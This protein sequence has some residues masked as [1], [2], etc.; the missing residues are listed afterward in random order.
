MATWFDEAYYLKAK[1]AQLK[2]V[3]EKDGNGNDYTLTT[4]KKAIADN[5]MTPEEH[6][7]AYGRSEGVNPNAYF[8]EAEYLQAKLEQLH[9]VNETDA[10]GNPYTLTTLKE[11]I[12]NIGLTPAEHYELYG[13]HETNKDGTLINPSNAFD[14]NAYAAAKLHQLQHGTAEERAAW[15]D[16]TPA[17]VMDAIRDA[18][19]SPVTHYMT[20]GAA[21]AN[22]GKVPMVQTVPSEQRVANDPHRDDFGQNVPSNYNAPTPAPSEADA[23][24]VTKPADMGGMASTD[25]SPQVV[26]PDKP[27]AVPGDKGYVTPPAG[28]VDTND[29]PVV[30]VVDPGSG[31]LVVP[32]TPDPTPTPDP[33]PTP[34]TPVAPVKPVFSDDKIAGDDTIDRHELL[35]GVAISGAA[36]AGSTVKILV[37]DNNAS[38]SDVTLT[39]TAAA[40]G[41]FTATLTADMAEGLKDG[42]LTLTAT[43]SNSGGTSGTTT[44]DG[45]TLDAKLN[46]TFSASGEKPAVK[47]GLT[48][49]EGFD[50]TTPG[51]GTL[52]NE[53]QTV[54]DNVTA[55]NNNQDYANVSALEKAAPN[56]AK[57]VHFYED[58]YTVNE[59]ATSSDTDGVLNLSAHDIYGGG[60]S[61][62]LA[63]LNAATGSGGRV[64]ALKYILGEAKFDLPVIK[65]S[66][67]NVVNLEVNKV[68]STITEK[69]DSSLWHNDITF[70]ELV[71]LVPGVKPIAVEANANT[72]DLRLAANATDKD[73]KVINLMEVR[74]TV[75][76]ITFSGT[77]GRFGI[78]VDAGNVSTIDASSL[79]D[80]NSGVY[81]NTAP[82]EV[83]VP[84][85]M[86]N[87]AK[88]GFHADSA[89]A[90]TFKGSAGNDILGVTQEV[91]GNTSSS[92]N[93][94][95]GD[96]TLALILPLEDK[97]ENAFV[98]KISANKHLSSFEHMAFVRLGNGVSVEDA[99]A[100]GDVKEFITT[101]DLHIE[102][103]TADQSVSTVGLLTSL[104]L[105]LS[106]K[107]KDTATT[108]NLAMTDNFLMHI[109]QLVGD[110][111]SS[112]MPHG[113]AV[114][115]QAENIGTLNL[116]SKDANALLILTEDALED[117]HNA[118]ASAKIE[119]TGYAGSIKIDDLRTSEAAT[120]VDAVKGFTENGL[121]VVND[122]NSVTIVYSDGKSS[123]EGDWT[124]QLVGFKG[125]VANVNLSR[126]YAGNYDNPF[127]DDPA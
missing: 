126:D 117:I 26:S 55:Q 119:A 106:A 67:T 27:V 23:A 5:G 45:I 31:Q 61:L 99:S 84:L 115:E 37:S 51:L 63:A 64:A 77:E 58:N 11:A 21:E 44:K 3:G 34:P 121:Y 9:S 39:T 41:T 85:N 50:N 19:M 100:F 101:T 42:K 47:L 95:G 22:A 13:S 65:A 36:K 59:K 116:T 24:P 123:T 104:A 57:L 105:E 79:T 97:G 92:F 2:A 49:P 48:A 113:A 86:G 80:K 71:G 107:E 72:L 69:I 89:E 10:H 62:S 125:A 91:Y 46:A 33:D 6:Y 78:N 40:N 52:M 7:N 17:D 73:A 60:L 81:V 56:F 54:Y 8:N 124:V 53:L 93:G 18:G 118:S 102:N 43:A 88:L 74:G 68:G 108:L 20:Y 76:N 75:E 109:D 103:L 70:S 32:T 96:D 38:T 122:D 83:S 25:V 98:A 15:A 110:T 90:L 4:L 127:A 30:P 14:A 94:E 87:E 29:H 66:A 120:T 16:K 111:Q 35:S 28:T 114:L 112:A 82:I 12:A 1:L